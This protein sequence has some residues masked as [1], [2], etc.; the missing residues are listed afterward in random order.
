MTRLPGRGALRL[1]QHVPSIGWNETLADRREGSLIPLPFR[2]ASQLADKDSRRL[3]ELAST[4]ARFS[5]SVS[6]FLSSELDRT[7][8][9]DADN[10]HL[11]G[12]AHGARLN[13]YS[14]EH[15]LGVGGSGITYKARED[16]TEREVAI[17]EYLPTALATRDRD[18]ITV[19]PLSASAAQDFEWG[20]ERFRQ[21]AKVLVEFHHPNIAPVLAYFEANS[22]GYLVMEFQDGNN[23][24]TMLRDAHTISETVALRFILPLLDGVEEV[25]RRG[26][27]HRDIKPENILIRR[28]GT[29]VLLDFG[30][31]RRAPSERSRKFT[32]ILT[33]GYAPFEQYTGTGNQGPWSDI[34]AIAAVMFR[35][36]TGRSPVGAPLR[37]TAKLSG[38]ADPLAR[39]F[40]T[41]RTRISSDVAFAIEAG[42]RVMDKE[43]PQSI[44]A[45]RELLASASLLPRYLPSAAATPS[46][47]T[48]VPDTLQ[49]SETPRYPPPWRPAPLPKPRR[50]RASVLFAAVIL[51][52]AGIALVVGDPLDWVDAPRRNGIENAQGPAGLPQ[53][54]SENAVGNRSHKHESRGAEDPELEQRRGKVLAEHQQRQLDWIEEERRQ[55]FA[56]IR[57]AESI[58]QKAAEAETKKRTDVQ[59]PARSPPS[60][61]VFPNASHGLKPW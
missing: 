11:F 29:P 38:E 26:L 13:S 15:V 33:E 52:V 48:L 42:L 37:A 55:F 46:A 50:A 35:A 23:L 8:A 1:P 6:N 39:D 17:K 34:Y 25:H 21:E 12:L 14:V 59:G 24:A 30:A 9:C 31:A 58:R 2:S 40:A 28:D 49:R 61:T 3:G 4:N 18:G 32:T 54:G 51:A 47:I 53:N 36:F 27:L 43:R 7:R 16:V 45:F 22:T 41:L 19:R 20:L 56:A 10:S 60:D 5:G 57:A 44:A